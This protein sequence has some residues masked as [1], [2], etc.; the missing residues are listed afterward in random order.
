MPIHTHTFDNGFRVIYE[1]PFNELKITSINVFCDIGSIH[2]PINCKGAAHFI[3][4]M[5]FK[6]TEKIPTAKDIYVEY[7]KMGAAFNAST[8]K[9]HTNYTA[10]CMDQY[11]GNCIHI[12]SDMLLNSRFQKREFVKE[13]KVVIE[14]N[15]RNSDIPY[16]I[17][18]TI[19]DSMLYSGSSYAEPVDDIKFHTKRFDYDSIVDIYQDFY[20]PSRMVLSIVTNVSFDEILNQVKHSFFVKNVDRPTCR[21]IEKYTVNSSVPLQR[22]IR[23]K[24]EIKPNLNTVQ[25]LLGFRVCNQFHRDKYALNL[26]KAILSGS[27]GSRMSMILREDNGLTYSS[28]VYTTYF[29]HSGDFTIFAEMDKTKILKNEI[30][31]K[32]HLG[33]LPLLIQMLND[34][35]AHGVTEDEVK[36]AKVNFRGKKMFSMEN[37]MNQSSHNGLELLRYSSTRKMVSMNK[38]YDVFYKDITKKDIHEVARTYLKKENM[39]VC[40]LG[41]SLPSLRMV[42]ETVGSL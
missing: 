31:N 27:M 10:K 37:N 19:L 15:I 24:F 17:A 6:G 2:E 8:E 41:S 23:Y 38:I 40:M 28:S 7:D 14:E 12:L 42:K 21:S 26:L 11:S 22:E 30:G 35:L 16:D 29:K 20:Q 32:A 4:H 34:L 36:L 3:E 33:V 5:C 13:E 1:K 25:L 9:Q 39:N 18:T